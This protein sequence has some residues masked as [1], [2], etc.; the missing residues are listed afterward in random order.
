MNIITNTNTTNIISNHKMNDKNELYCSNCGH[1]NH[2]FKNCSEPVNSYG[3]L[4][5]YK[6]KSMVKFK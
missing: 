4:C 2:V 5:F 6:K 1:D 3:L